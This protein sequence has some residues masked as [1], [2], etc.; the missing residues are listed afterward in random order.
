VPTRCRML[1]V[2]LMN[3]EPLLAAC[4][5]RSRRRQRCQHPHEQRTPEPSR[6]P[7]ACDRHLIP[8]LLGGP[9]RCARTGAPV[10]VRTQ[11]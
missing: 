2:Q 3:T 5:H 6:T 11:T 1:A 4:I 8:P 10:A 9:P 7:S